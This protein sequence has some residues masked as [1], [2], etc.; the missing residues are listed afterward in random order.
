MQLTHDG[1]DEPGHA[2][3][4]PVQAH[5][6]VVIDKSLEEFV[7]YVISPGKKRRKPDPPNHED[8][9]T[10]QIPRIIDSVLVSPIL[11][12]CVLL[13]SINV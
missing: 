1:E 6:V 5:K 7:M 4:E 10:Y 11:P 3:V 9:S 12:I 8:S 13:I 2:E